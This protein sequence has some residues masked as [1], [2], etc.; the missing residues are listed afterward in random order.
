MYQEAFACCAQLGDA[1]ADEGDA[2]ARFT[3]A[4]PNPVVRAQARQHLR[5]KAI[6]AV[7]RLVGVLKDLK[8]VAEAM[9]V[10]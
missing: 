10:L 5:D 7:E 1:W 2:L 9:I 8:P 6:A 3:A 4:F